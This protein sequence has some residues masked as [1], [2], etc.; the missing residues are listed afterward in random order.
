MAL[1]VASHREFTSLLDRAPTIARQ[2]LPTLVARLRGLS[3][4][5]HSQ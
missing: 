1:L 4:D 3:D 2:M 5:H